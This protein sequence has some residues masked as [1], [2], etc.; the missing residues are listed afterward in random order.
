MPQAVTFGEGGDVRVKEVKMT[1]AGTVGVLTTPRGEIPFVT[2]LLGRYNLLNLLAAAAAAEALGLRHEAVTAA[3]AAQR[4]VPGRMEPV[5]RGQPF[6]VFVDYAHTD[7]ALDAAIRSA[8][9][10]AG[11]GKVAVVFGCGGD[12]DRGKR[13]LM[14]RVAGELAALPILTSDNPRTEDPLAILASVEEGVK[15]SGNQ[16]Y[17]VIPDRRE[18]IREAIFSAEAGWAVLV[19][20]KGH[21]REQIV[22]DRKLPFSDFEEIE[23]A[24]EERFGTSDRG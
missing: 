12:R 17:R 20:G 24:L 9:E 14:G 19:A 16:E 18:A 2:H 6:P 7:A 5:D 10:I 15:A 4:P 21:E 11:T 23:K 1:P 8:R 13:P 3:L 22:G